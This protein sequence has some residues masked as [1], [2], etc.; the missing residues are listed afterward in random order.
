MERFFIDANFHYAEIVEVSNGEGW[1]L[2]DLADQVAGK[3]Y[4][5]NMDADFTIVWLD[6]ERRAEPAEVIEAT[7]MERL[8][9]KGADP[10]KTV[11]CVPDRMTENVILA[12]E[13]LIRS[14][15]QLPGYVYEL[16]GRGGKHHLEALFA[17]K[18]INY[19]ETS[20]GADLL[21]RV[22]LVRAA[23]KNKAAKKLLDAVPIDCWWKDQGV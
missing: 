10:D 18:Q 14:Q 7:I 22:R 1:S 3:F 17:A 11:V 12:D 21:K 20:H 9:V 4:T 13:Q 2:H 23:Q 5:K 15:F 6:K 16:E 19:K 8:V